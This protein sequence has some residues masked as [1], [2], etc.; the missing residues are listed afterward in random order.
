MAGRPRKVGLDYFE[1]D[2]LLDDKVKLIQ[3]E[4]GLKGFAVIVK[5]YQKIYGTEGYYCEW[6]EKILLLFLVENGLNGDSKN[7]IN[8]IIKACIREGIFSEKLYKKFNILTSEGV[9]KRYLNATSKR[10]EVNL[11]KEYLLISVG[12][13]SNNVVINS[14]SD[15]RNSIN[16]V[17][18]SQS[19]V[20]ESKVENNIYGDSESPPAPSE[21]LDEF[22]ESIWKHYPVK[23]GKGSVSKTQKMKLQRIGYDEIIRCVERYCKEIKGEDRQFWKHGSTF[24]N[25]GYVDYLDCNYV[26]DTV[27]NSEFAEDDRF[28]SLDISIRKELERL[29]IIEGQSLNL[30]NATEAQI[31]ILQKAGV[32]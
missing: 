13:N 26:V 16:S 25:S 5:L 7:L 10:E 2:C 1:L 24:F 3:A 11:K 20:E 31:V 9:Q 18:N 17:R 27:C 12:K 21:S 22:Y 8:E 29:G 15:G 14:I 19:K 32:L 30:G 28:E 23:K 6:N 4:F